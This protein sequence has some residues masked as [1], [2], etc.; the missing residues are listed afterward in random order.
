METKEALG[1]S[2][3]RLITVD[4]KPGGMPGVG[5]IHELYSSARHKLGGRP[6][7]LLAAEA[8]LSKVKL[9]GN[10]FLV[11]GCA[12]IP[13]LPHGEND[14]PLGVASIA[15]AINFGLGATPIFIAGERDVA[16]LRSTVQAAGVHIEDYNFAKR[17]KSSAGAI[18]PFPY[19]D[20]EQSKEVAR[21][22]IDKYEPQAVIS[23][24]ALGPNEVSV[25]H[26]A[27]G[28]CDFGAYAPPLSEQLA[29]LECLFEESNKREILTIA[30][31]DNGNEIGSGLIAEDVRRI[32]PFGGVCQCPCNS[33]NACVT[34]ADIPIPASTSNLGAYGIAAMLAY[35]LK[36]PKILQNVDTHHRMLQACIEAGSIDPGTGAGTMSEDG[37]PIETVKAFLNILHTIIELGLVTSMRDM[38]KAGYGILTPPIDA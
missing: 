34:K 9:D 8:I 37:L 29:H 2:V 7:T 38:A 26:N 13:M 12:C 32:M 24:E 5:L 21:E 36:K 1:G 19:V 4:A 20:F 23:V 10:V 25:K 16:P 31:L 6:L 33:G 22:L 14:G 28:I 30:T 15:R 27:T 11:T 17:L 18:I 3:D 35:L